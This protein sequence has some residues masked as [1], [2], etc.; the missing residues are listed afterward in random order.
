MRIKKES[1]GSTLRVGCANSWFNEKHI[2][3]TQ[4]S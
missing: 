1:K 2:E 3:I 4:L